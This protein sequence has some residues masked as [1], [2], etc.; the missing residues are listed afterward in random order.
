MTNDNTHW[1]HKQIEMSEEVPEALR[2]VEQRDLKRILHISWDEEFQRVKIWNDE[3][4][5]L[6]SIGFSITKKGLLENNLELFK[7]NLENMGHAIF[8]NDH[9]ANKMWDNCRKLAD[10]DPVFPCTSHVSVKLYLS[11]DPFLPSKSL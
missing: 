6:S 3:S 7:Q 1:L 11:G 8:S 5:N 10:L 2:S 4:D 9:W